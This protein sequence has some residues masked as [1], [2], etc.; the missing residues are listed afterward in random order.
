VIEDHQTVGARIREWSEQYGLYDGEHG[1][2][3]TDAKRERQ[4]RGDREGRLTHETTE[5]VPQIVERRAELL[6]RCGRVI[7]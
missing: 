6:R 3:A 1:Y 2:V 7:G 5:G 4:H